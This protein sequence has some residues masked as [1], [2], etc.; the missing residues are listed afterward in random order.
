MICIPNPLLLLVKTHL[1]NW[2]FIK[3]WFKPDL[4]DDEPHH[5]QKKCLELQTTDIDEAALVDI[6]V[7]P[8]LLGWLGPKKVPNNW[9]LDNQSTITSGIEIPIIKVL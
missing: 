8:R 6:T 7:S 2:N 3:E 5:A 4:H 9:N 1:D